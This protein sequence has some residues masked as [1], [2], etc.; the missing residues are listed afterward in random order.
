MIMEKMTKMNAYVV[1]AYANVFYLPV[2][3]NRWEPCV[4]AHLTG[5]VRGTPCVMLC[6]SSKTNEVCWI[7]HN[8]VPQLSKELGVIDGSR[9][10]HHV[11]LQWRSFNQA[12]SGVSFTSFF[13]LKKFKLFD[14]I[15]THT[16]KL[17]P[18]FLSMF[19]PNFLSSLAFTFLKTACCWYLQ[20][21][22]QTLLITI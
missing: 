3:W 18:E 5:E 20:S 12:A 17:I 21:R 2:L 13:Y 6:S 8:I 22:T 1:F 10:W 15:C 14:H 19:L 16:L 9:T 7:K 11:R 4:W